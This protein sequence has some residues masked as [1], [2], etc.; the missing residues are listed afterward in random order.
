M[1]RPNRVNL[2]EFRLEKMVVW[3]RTIAVE[4]ERG[5]QIH[6]L[7]RFIMGFRHTEPENSLRHSGNDIK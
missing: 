6:R 2:Q 3:A 5:E 4:K 7:L 1:G